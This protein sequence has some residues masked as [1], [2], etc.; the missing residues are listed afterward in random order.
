MAHPFYPLEDLGFDQQAKREAPLTFP[1]AVRRTSHQDG[2]ERRASCM[3]ATELDSKSR[4]PGRRRIQVAVSR[5][6]HLQASAD[7]PVQ[8]MPQEEDQVQRRHRRRTG[9]FQLS[10]LREYQL[11]FP[12]GESR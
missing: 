12:E 7:R 3:S 5:P 1:R 11:P 10:Q 4:N 8:S 6:G 9:L 2:V